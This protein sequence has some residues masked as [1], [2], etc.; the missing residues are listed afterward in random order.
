MKIWKPVEHGSGLKHPSTHLLLPYCAGKTC[1]GVSESERANMCPIWGCEWAN[2]MQEQ[3]VCHWTNVFVCA[4]VQGLKVSS[5]AAAA[6]GCC[7]THPCWPVQYLRDPHAQ[8]VRIGCKLLV[9]HGLHGFLIQFELQLFIQIEV[10]QRPERPRLLLQSRT[11]STCLSSMCL[12]W[13][14]QSSYTK[15][16]NVTVELNVV[17]LMSVYRLWWPTS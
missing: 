14:V 7:H 10:I 6:P 5:K 3:Y 8:N 4:A 11:F 2:F 17:K 16:H 1:T 15:K 12:H 9:E 13:A